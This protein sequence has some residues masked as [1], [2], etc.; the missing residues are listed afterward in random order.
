MDSSRRT[1]L[2]TTAGLSAAALVPGLA[3]L[4]RFPAHAAGSDVIKVGVVGCGGRGTGAAVNCLDAD[5]GVRIVALG[6]LFEERVKGCQAELAKRGERAT[7]A[8][9]RCFSGF[10]AYQKVAAADVDV[11]ILAAPPGFRP[12]HIRAAVDAG[13]HVFCEKPVATCPTGIRAFLESV[14]IAKTKNLAIVAGTQRRHEECYLEAFK[15]IEDGAIGDIVSAEVYWLQGGLWHVDR[16]P[17][18]SDVEWQIRNWLYFTWLAGDTIVEQHVHQ[19]DVAA[20]ALGANPVKAIS[21]GGRSS[22]T[23]PVFGN[24]YDHFTTELE[25][26]NGVRVTSWS[27]QIDKTVGR[28]SEHLVGTKGRA[29][30]ASGFARIAGPQAWTWKNKEAPSPYVQEHV[31]LIRSIRAGAPI[32]EG[33]QVAESTLA[34]IMGR[35]AAYTGQEVTWDFAMK[36]KLALFPKKLEFGPFPCDEVAMPGKTPLV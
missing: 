36:S 9:D 28:V 4:G 25:Y 15:R 20:W 31:D 14:E 16:K 7:V 30:L 13:R 34:A 26:P 27:R 8:A 18:Y 35:M 3:P 1:F 19:I 21:V 17:E 24:V 2:K 22:R 6:D 12:S 32:N 10:D 11:V 29:D 23:D 33:R 5:P